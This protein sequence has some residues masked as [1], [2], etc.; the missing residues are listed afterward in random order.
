VDLWILLICAE[1]VDYGLLKRLFEIG[2]PV[3]MV[4]ND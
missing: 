4:L 3:K 1:E 2:L